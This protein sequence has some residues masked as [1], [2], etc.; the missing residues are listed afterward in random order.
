MK[1]AWEGGSISCM[2][3]QVG[4]KI[5]RCQRDLQRWSKQSFCNISRALIEKR[6][7]LKSVEEI[8]QLGGDYNPVYTIKKEISELLLLKEQL[9]HQRSC[10]HW[11]KSGDKNTTFFH[12]K[13]SQR[14]RR[15]S[16]VSLR[17]NDGVLC[18]DEVEV[19]G[20]LVSYYKQFFTSSQPTYFEAV[21]Q[22]SHGWSPMK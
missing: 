9:W 19:T 17:N 8:A 16:I 3:S 21:L 18:S 15:N 12:S 6:S 11:M 4:E 7:F 14:L 2:I 13:A 22:E 1:T 5:K 20:L 10:A